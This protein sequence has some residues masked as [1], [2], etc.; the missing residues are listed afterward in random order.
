MVRT[1]TD[2]CSTCLWTPF[3]FFLH[4]R[5][6]RGRGATATRGRFDRQGRQPPTAQG[7]LDGVAL[8]LAIEGK[9]DEPALQVLR[10]EEA[11]A[12]GAQRQVQDGALGGQFD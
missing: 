4:C 3:P 10:E 8:V 9:E 1:Q 5:D 2:F 6:G 11:A 7:A 12:V